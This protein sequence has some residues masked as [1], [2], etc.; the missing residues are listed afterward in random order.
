MTM[1]KQN[2]LSERYLNEVAGGVGEVARIMNCFFRTKETLD[3]EGLWCLQEIRRNASALFISELTEIQ[4]Q[5]I[6]SFLAESDPV[7]LWY[8]MT[9][10]TDEKILSQVWR[11]LYDINTEITGVPA[12]I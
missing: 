3:R 11:A 4:G 8:G 2:Q 7:Y 1:N 9:T 6:K 12:I 5:A 10:T